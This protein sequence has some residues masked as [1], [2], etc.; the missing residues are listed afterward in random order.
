M[1]FCAFYNLW[2]FRLMKFN[3]S[4]VTRPLFLLL[5]GFAIIGFIIQLFAPDIYFSSQ[6]GVRNYI[7]S[8]EPFDRVVF[9]LTQI[10]QVILA[11]ISHYIV[12]L[13]G[14]ALYGA[15]EGGVLNW[16]GRVIGH[17]IAYWIGLT[18]GRKIILKIFNPEDLNKFQK[19]ING[20]KQTLYIRVFILFA[21]MFL[22]LF[23]DDEISYL[24]GIAAFPFKLYL[25]II[26]LGHLGGSFGLSYIG[27]GM[28][29]KDPFF[30]IIF[31]STILLAILLAFAVRKLNKAK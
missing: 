21:I 1:Q 17:L 16:I 18:L 9:V 20:T 5:T 27:A 2:Y 12:G 25:P 3:L 7:Q 30:W 22:P 15:F 24:M 4:S 31:G 8:F 10:L 6:E 26:L 14:G 19:F 28:D 29:G 13:L 23:P 11:P